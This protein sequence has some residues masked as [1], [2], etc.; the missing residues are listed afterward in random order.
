ML[1][2]NVRDRKF[3]R[4]RSG[5]QRINTE[6][7]IR[8]RHI[9]ARNAVMCYMYDLYPYAKYMDMKAMFESFKLSYTISVALYVIDFRK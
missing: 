6:A 2:T 8:R 4:N 5:A 9:Y 1:S 3:T 7:A